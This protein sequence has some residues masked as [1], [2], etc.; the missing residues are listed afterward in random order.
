MCGFVGACVCMCGFVGAC[1]CVCLCVCV[2]ICLRK[3]TCE[4]TRFFIRNLRRGLGLKFLHSFLPRNGVKQILTKNFV[5][6][7]FD[8][9]MPRQTDLEY[10][11]FP[12]DKSQYDFF[13]FMEWIY[14]EIMYLMYYKNPIY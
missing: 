13:P 6:P 7:R 10:W 5:H 3:F 11:N 4:V 12:K 8:N 9:F 1:V 14:T 2:C